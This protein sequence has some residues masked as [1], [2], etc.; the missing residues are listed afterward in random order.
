[1]CTDQQAASHRCVDCS[2][3]ICMDCVKIHEHLKQYQSHEVLE[4]QSLLTGEVKKL[5]SFSSTKNKFCPFPGHE[6]ENIN[7]FCSNPCLKPICILCALNTHKDHSFSEFSKVREGII[8]K[9]QEKMR[10]VLLKSN[11]AQ[12]SLAELTTIDE[13]NVQK[14][15]ELQNEIRIYFG[16]AKKAVEERENSLLGAVS[17]KLSNK[18]TFVEN[19]KKRLTSFVDSCKQAFYYGRLSFEINNVQSY[20]YVAESIQLRLENLEDQLHENQATYETMKFSRKPSITSYETYVHRLG[21]LLSSDAISSRSNVVITPLVCEVHQSVQF[22]IKLLSSIGKEIVDEKVNVFIEL[23]GKVVTNIQ[24][25]VEKSSFYTGCWI[26]DEAKQF[27][28]TVVSNGIQMETLHGILD[29]QTTDVNAKKGNFNENIFQCKCI[30]NIPLYIT[31]TFRYF[32][33][34]ENK[35]SAFIVSIVVL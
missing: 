18:H 29:V 13:T 24:C 16:E 27:A 4:I 21:K 33:A 6:K 20:L 19:E 26:P 7:L 10:N 9:V 11:I 22:Q 14:S 32:F 23:N 31:Y 2:L 28:W 5:R 12:A 1:M 8:S 30:H 25:A 15:L 17:A 35:D 34:V 3:F